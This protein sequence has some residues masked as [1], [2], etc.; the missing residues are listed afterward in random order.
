MTLGIFLITKQV[1]VTIAGSYSHYGS[2]SIV[3]IFYKNSK[4]ISISNKD[5]TSIIICQ[6]LQNDTNWNLF[7]LIMQS[8]P[9]HVET[10]SVYLSLSHTRFY[11]D[12]L[13]H[14]LNASL[15]MFEVTISQCSCLQSLW[16]L[17]SK[18][19]EDKIFY[20]EVCFDV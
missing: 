4:N 11:T 9:F 17:M 13:N 5:V 7:L 12:L 14:C 10:N 16:F 20:F 8:V 1:S 3:I 15:S 6:L 18:W 2:S 19:W